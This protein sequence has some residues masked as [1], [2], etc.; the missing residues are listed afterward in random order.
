MSLYPAV[1]SEFETLRL[2]CEGRSLARYGDGEFKLCA[3]SSIKSQRA[4][5]ALQRRLRTILR[6]AGACLVGIPNIH[7]AT[8]KGK[9]W[10]QFTGMAGWLADR[11]YVSAFVS[12]PD[13]A[14]WIDT[15]EY[16]A[17][18]ESLWRGEAVTLVRGSTK[19]LTAEDL[20]GAG[21]VTEIVGPRQHAWAEYGTLLDRIGHPARALLCLGPTAT[22]LAADLCARG[23]HAVDLGHVGMFVRKHRRGEP[24]WVTKE[25]QAP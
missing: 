18:L 16:W 12:R 11:P 6:D 5:L 7:S 14:P 22:V 3:G 21:D 17:Q 8:P 24:L 9:F 13:S 23:V 2:V 15:P 4:D 25:D 19:S 20:I 1:A 10:S